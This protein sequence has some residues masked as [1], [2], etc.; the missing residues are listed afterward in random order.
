MPCIVQATSHA[1]TVFFFN[2]TATTE[3]YTLSLHDA[4]P[5]SISYFTA[6]PFCWRNRRF[7]EL[8]NVLENSNA[9]AGQEWGMA[10]NQRPPMEGR[11]LLAPVRNAKGAPYDRPWMRIAIHQIPICLAAPVPIQK[12]RP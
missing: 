8:K 1:A 6:V 12:G 5:I 2:D 9:G 11:T 3:I 7:F 4:L 10:I